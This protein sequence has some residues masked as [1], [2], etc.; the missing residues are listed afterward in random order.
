M[1]K[2]YRLTLCHAVIWVLCYPLLQA[3]SGKDAPPAPVPE[4]IVA[5]RRVFIS[6]GG[7]ALHF[8]FF[9][10]TRAYN[11]FYAA[12]K[13]WGRFTVTASPA[14]ADLILE[15]S[16]DG[17]AYQVGHEQEVIPFF[18]LRLRDPKTQTLLWV[19][20]ENLERSGILGIAE[21]LKFDGAMAR[22]VE[23]LKGLMVGQRAKP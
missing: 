3:Q 12:I 6:N 15:I 20:N 17:E 23:D 7:N 10:P 8:N 5:A 13:E 11:Q 9:K 19:F 16:L 21:N 4:Q 2:Q 14:E 1:S 22:I 18:K